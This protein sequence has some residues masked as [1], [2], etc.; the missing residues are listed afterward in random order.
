M[1]VGVECR[2]AVPAPDLDRQD[3]I[4]KTAFS[5]A[6]AVP[7]TRGRRVLWYPELPGFGPQP[8]AALGFPAIRNITGWS[9]RSPQ[10]SAIDPE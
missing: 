7:P 10:I 8:A 9:A 5:M 3:L 2:N 4:G 6:I 1:F